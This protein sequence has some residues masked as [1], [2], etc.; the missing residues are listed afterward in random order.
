ML[1]PNFK[2]P[3]VQQRLRQQKNEALKVIMSE[4]IDN[5]FSKENKNLKNLVDYL[6]T[7]NND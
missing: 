5:P 7:D 3:K 6:D 4:I 1:D 2:D